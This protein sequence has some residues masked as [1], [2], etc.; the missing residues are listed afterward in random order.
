MELETKLKALEEVDFLTRW[1]KQSVKSRLK[2][3]KKKNSFEKIDF[4]CVF[5]GCS[6]Y[7]GL[8]TGGS[9]NTKME[10][11]QKRYWLLV[12][13]FQGLETSQLFFF[14][15]GGR[16]WGPEWSNRNCRESWL[17]TRN[18]MIFST[19]WPYLLVTV[20]VY[21]YIYTY[22]YIYTYTYIYVY[23][24]YVV[25]ICCNPL[26]LGCLTSWPVAHNFM[27]FEPPTSRPTGQL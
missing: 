10:L 21:L 26:P 3:G 8:T 18:G 17:P 11:N 23:I 25:V 15:G 1:V 7:F 12:S 20:L 5:S 16:G 2:Y 9:E 24:V 4:L 6:A 14:L 13:F 22:I 27:E 19:I